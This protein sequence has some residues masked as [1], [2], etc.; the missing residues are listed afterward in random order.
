[1]TEIH[2]GWPAWIAPA[3]SPRTVYV[4]INITSHYADLRIMPML[5]RDRL[6]GNGLGLA[7][8]A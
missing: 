2:D 1:M 5:S 3:G 8:S 4:K 6:A 7:R